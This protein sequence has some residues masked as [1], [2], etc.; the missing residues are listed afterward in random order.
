L[1]TEVQQRPPLDSREMDASIRRAVEGAY[2]E[3]ARQIADLR[4][5]LDVYARAERP[6]IVVAD[7]LAR[8]PGPRRG[9]L[10]FA[11]DEQTLYGANASEW[12]EVGGGGGGA[13]HN[14]DEYLTQ[15]EGD[16]LYAPAGSVGNVGSQAAGAGLTYA[17]GALNVGAGNLI[18]VAPDSVSLTEGAVY[19]FVGTGNSATPAYRDIGS[20][21]G[22]GLGHTDG[23]LSVGVDN[24]GPVGLTQEGNSI[25][26]TSS[27]DPRQQAKVLATDASGQT[28]LH[29]LGLG[30]GKILSDASA[31]QLR[32]ADDSA[33]QPLE[34]KQLRNEDGVYASPAA[35]HAFT[36][37]AGAL[38]PARAASLL[39]SSDPSHAG[40]IPAANGLYALGKSRID[41]GLT[42]P[43][44]DTLTGVDMNVAPAGD[45]YLSPA[46]NNAV[47]SQAAALRSDNFLKTIL[48]AGFR[49]G[50]TLVPGQTAIQAGSGEFDELRARVF[51][52]DETRVD[53][54]QWYLTKSYGI[55]SRAFT[56]PTTVG[57]AAWMYVENSPNVA[58]ALFSPGDY[59]MFGYLKIDG[60]IVLTKLWG[61]V[62]NYNVAGLTGEQRWTFTLQQGEAPDP[63]E[64]YEFPK[65]AAAFDFGQSGQGY[66]LMDAVTGTAPNMQIGRWTGLPW[67]PAAYKVFTQ[68]GRLDAIG[69]TGQ[70][71]LAASTIADGYTTDDSWIRIGSGGALLNN[72][73]L[74]FRRTGIGQTV[75]WQADGSLWIGSAADHK[76]EF[77]AASGQMRLSNSL[78]IGSGVGF[79]TDALLY[80]PFDGGDPRYGQSGS[81]NGH[82]GQPATLVG[83]PAFRPGKF[84]GSLEA[85]CSYTNLVAN[86]SFEADS[87]AAGNNAIG[88]VPTGWNSTYTYTAGGGAVSGSRLVSDLASYDGRQCMRIV[89][90]GQESPVIP[91]SRLG[92]YCDVTVVAGTEYAV[93]GWVRLGSLTNPTAGQSQAVMYVQVQGSSPLQ[94]AQAAT[95]SGNGWT[96][97]QLKITPTTTTLRVYFWLTNCEAGE[98]YVDAVQVTAGAIQPYWPSE[99]GVRPFSCVIIPSLAGMNWQQYTISTWFRLAELPSNS[100]A[101]NHYLYHV[102]AGTSGTSLLV[103]SANRLFGYYDTL[104]LSGNPVSRWTGSTAQATVSDDGWHH[105]ALVV[106]GLAMSL[107]YDGALVGVQTLVA[108]AGGVPS[109]VIGSNAAT[110]RPWNGWIDDFAIIPRALTPIQIAQIAQ[111]SAPLRVLANAAE[112]LLSNVTASGGRN[113]VYGHSGGLFGHWYSPAGVEQSSFA[114]IND[115]SL[116]SWGGIPSPRTGD[117][118][119]GD[120]RNSGGYMQY[121][122]STKA[123]TIKAIVNIVGGNAAS[124]ADLAGKL[125]VGEAAD[126]IN[127]GSTVIDGGKI[128]ASSALS[129][130]ASRT[131]QS[132][133]IQLQFNGGNPR[134]YI[135]NAA[136]TRY[137]RY[138]GGVLTWKAANTELDATGSLI[139]SGL[140][141]NSATIGN[142]LANSNGVYIPAPTGYDLN[143]GYK[144]TDA[145][146]G[147]IGGLTMAHASNS[148]VSLGLW[149]NAN[150]ELGSAGTG[151]II[152]P[153]TSSYF[154]VGS[155]ARGSAGESALS[156]AQVMA[157]YITAAGVNKSATVQVQANAS[158]SR[159]DLTAD[160]VYIYPG[161]KIWH[162]GY[163][164]PIAFG[165]A[166]FFTM[167]RHGAIVAGSST[168]PPMP[169]NY[170]GNW[171]LAMTHNAKIKDGA[172]VS[173]IGSG[174]R[175]MAMGISHNLFWI[176][177][178][179]AAAS[180]ADQAITW[181][182]RI[183]IDA[184]GNF[185]VVGTLGGAW[186]AGIGIW[187]GSNGANISGRQDFGYRKFGD[188]VFFRGC[189]GLDGEGGADAHIGTIP[190]GYR[191]ASTVAWVALTATGVVEAYIVG[192]DGGTDAGK[193]RMK[194][195]GGDQDY[196]TFDGFFYPV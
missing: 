55:L 35:A 126:D 185:G 62:G 41:G 78:L 162:D 12:F 66:I 10:A 149:S 159:I 8:F 110:S 28:T 161:S 91:S 45:L 2:R 116:S 90:E 137:L 37:I 132:A 15:A 67:E 65:G 122:A 39:A 119:I 111:G 54:G 86:S 186:N 143:K 135:G 52:A 46:G 118:I 18:A 51:V 64:P 124:T 190:A 68:L 38:A 131:W 109:V 3:T 30:L 148:F 142:V 157:K 187:T 172:W 44:L 31:Y 76:L 123:L 57:G 99:N 94:T 130:G 63:L 27:S 49:I 117:V 25:R 84:G 166:E 105:T 153:D 95:A 43:L 136:V 81:A 184:D 98:M 180:A 125:S 176:S 177:G 140:T 194:S 11:I 22:G 171:G 9:A 73:P 165:E 115:D 20:L 59:V 121:D 102:S 16:A 4:S 101:L 75:D 88:S 32:N 70:I 21:A 36:T 145:S 188:L 104:D 82:L 7:A 150:T 69:F 19:Q 128:S 120:S 156:Q 139:A 175:P 79:A 96:Q 29:L 13:A 134:A 42:T 107:Y 71:G 183:G 141:V 92:T 97:L 152:K 114:L 174:H 50:P 133:G 170:M 48:T 56:V 192:T 113:E 61:T 147:V 173:K 53:R 138:E 146:A 182:Q 151:N 47:V 193:I 154:A 103:N 169:S 168:L 108:S 160:E 74:Q 127:D 58:G 60:G 33:Y 178:S 195:K 158:G 72:L 181:T 112:I 14:H 196:I 34:I 40:R 89:K 17:A 5:R 1:K 167:N 77:D 189:A 26:L 100:T 83:Q 179:N 24:T 129:I 164:G 80:C 163:R 191:P 85:A 144:F 155:A 23:V 106:D 6:D 87:P 93:S